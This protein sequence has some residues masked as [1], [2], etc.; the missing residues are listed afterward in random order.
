[1]IVAL[2]MMWVFQVPLAYFIPEVTTLGVYGVRWAMIAGYVWA[3][4]AAAIYFRVGR[5][6]RKEV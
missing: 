2:V 1:M 5:W 6:K 3:A 4:L